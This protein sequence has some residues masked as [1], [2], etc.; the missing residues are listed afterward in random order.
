[1]GFIKYCA[2]NATV[3]EKLLK[4]GFLNSFLNKRALDLMNIYERQVRKELQGTRY[5]MPTDIYELAE[6]VKP[7][8]STGNQTGEGWFLTAEM[9]ELMKD[10]IRNIVCVQP[11]AC[12]PNHIVGKAVIKQI[13]K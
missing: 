9:I 1:M 13:R 5:R 7:V 2:Y 6:N 11:F 4:K 8:L 10:G 12:L 3:K